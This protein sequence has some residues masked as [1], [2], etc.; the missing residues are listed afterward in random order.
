MSN[1]DAVGLMR[2]GPCSTRPQNVH[3]RKLDRDS[4]VG[5]HRRRVRWTHRGCFPTGAAHASADGGIARRSGRRAS[6]SVLGR[7]AF[8]EAGLGGPANLE[9]LTAFAEG[10]EPDF[11]GL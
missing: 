9:A 2:R 8:A 3:S 10:R 5:G 11:T 4:R 6:R 7:A 1:G